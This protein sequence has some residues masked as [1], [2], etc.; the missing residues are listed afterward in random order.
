MK[1]LIILLA[2]LLIS[3]VT[4]AQGGLENQFYFRF[5]YSIPSW[6]QYGG[7]KSEWE[8]YNV[9]RFGFSGEVGSIFILGSISLPEG[10][11]LGANVDYLSFYWHQIQGDVNLTTIRWG[12]KLGPSFSYSLADQV[13]LD[14]FVKADL[15]W[16]TTGD[17][18]NELSESVGFENFG[19]IGLSAGFNIRLNIIM[20]GVEFNTINQMLGVHNQEGNYMGNFIDPDDN[21]DKSILPSLTFSL[22]L[23]F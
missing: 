2:A 15:C 21:G 17:F 11:V 7:T 16:L 8:N 10:M 14:A 23:S 9:Q 5:G 20:L 22:G 19:A 12:S 1:K 18:T 3:L 13:T 6:K 4:L